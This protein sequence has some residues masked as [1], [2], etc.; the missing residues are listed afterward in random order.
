MSSVGAFQGMGGYQEQYQNDHS[1]EFHVGSEQDSYLGE[2][3]LKQTK[4]HQ[5]CHT[6]IEVIYNPNIKGYCSSTKK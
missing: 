2:T 3:L 1:S 6:F 4:I 5:I